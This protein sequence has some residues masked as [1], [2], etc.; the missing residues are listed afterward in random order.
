[1]KKPMVRKPIAMLFLP[2]IFEKFCVCEYSLRKGGGEKILD[3]VM[4]VTLEGDFC[5]G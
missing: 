4:F 5:R 2:F 1:M 3:E